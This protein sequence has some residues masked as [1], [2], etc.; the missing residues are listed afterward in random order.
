[1]S[2]SRLTSL[3]WS[4][5]AGLCIVL[6]LAFTAPAA[7]AATVS[8]RVEVPGQALVPMADVALPDARVAPPTASAGE[9]CS[10]NTVIGAV[11]AATNG[12]WGGVWSASEGWSLETING[13]T[14][15]PDSGRQWDVYV[16]DNYVNDKPCFSTLAD[17]DRVLIFPRCTTAST[18]CFTG[19]PLTIDAPAFASPR[20]LLSIQVWQ[21]DTVFSSGTGGSVRS[22]GSVKATV[23]APA[24]NTKTDDYYGI[25]TVPMNDGGPNLIT[26][27]NGNRPPGRWSVCVT[28]GNDGYCGTT[29]P[30]PNPFDPYKFCT[31]TG[32]DGLCGSVD[33]TPAASLITTPR[34]G[35][36]FTSKSPLKVLKGQV[37]SDPNGVDRVVI[38]LKRQVTI[39][40]KK[41]VRKRKIRNKR[42]QKVK[43]KRIYRTR[44]VKRCYG[45]NTTL[46]D[47]AKLKSCSSVPP[48]FK[49]DGDEFWSFEF[50]YALAKGAYTLEAIS[51]DGKG[52]VETAL[53]PGRNH[54]TFTVK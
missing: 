4:H 43:V 37:A 5:L 22:G 9:S 50:L 31:T 30:P 53:E 19:G 2:K 28:A 52:N 16:N 32:S 45:W 36:V 8:F 29:I 48:W 25:A 15:G 14:F 27:I 33:T 23:I 6:A 40:V 39:K 1:M 38:R 54:V 26:V 21:I 13:R 20:A 47:W 7:N 18:N 51:T 34:Q 42:T 11:A 49:V 17:K 41:L 10:G 46:S 3:K 44:S 35:T 24:G 12:S